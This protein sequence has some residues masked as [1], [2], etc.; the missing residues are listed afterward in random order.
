VS[1]VASQI[2]SKSF[3]GGYRF[4]SFAGGP[5]A[6]IETV[7]VPRAVTLRKAE[8]LRAVIGRGEQVRA[9]QIVAR[10]DEVVCSPIPSPVSGTVEVVTGEEIVISSDGS[11][12]WRPV[13]GHTGEWDNLIPVRIEEILYLAGATAAVPGGIPTRY[14]TAPIEPDQVEHVIVHDTAAEP[15]SPRSEVLLADHGVGALVQGIGILSKLMPQAG[16]HVALDRS[17]IRLLRELASSD[18]LGGVEMVALPGRYPQAHDAVLVPAVIGGRYP[19]GYDAIHMGVLTL[20]IQALVHVYEAVTM[21][22]PLIERTVALSGS[23]FREGLHVRVRIG[24]PV[25]QVVAPYRS[26][27]PA[28]LVINSVLSGRAV[29]QLTDP[30]ERDCSQLI[31]LP[32]GGRELLGWARPGFRQDSFSRTFMADLV[33]AARTADT[34]IHGEHRPCI[35]CGFCNRVCPADILPHLLHRYVQRGYINEELAGL[36]ILDCIDC[37]LCT[38]VC[39]SKIPLASLIADGKQKVIAEGLVTRED[40]HH[41]FSLKGLD[42]SETEADL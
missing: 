13:S 3:A 33:P 18:R 38:Y 32:E 24:T 22:K 27:E 11:P 41:R 23:G 25:E 21:G 26:Q 6:R 5:A 20:D 14:R 42:A 15:Y 7:A 16:I 35:S 29:A 31:A 19:Y 10:A 39:P 40:I 28:A 30:V 9:G 17:Q 1:I 34:G 2:R 4:R 8:K 12:E 36:R 37:N